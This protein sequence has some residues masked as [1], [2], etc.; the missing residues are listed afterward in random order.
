MVRVP[1]APLVIAGDGPE[2]AELERMARDL[3]LRY[4]SF[5]GLLHGSQLEETIAKCCFSV[6]PSHAYETLGKSILESYAWGRPVV[7][8]DHGSRRELMEHGVT[9][10]LYPVGDREQLA[11]AIELLFG[12]ADLAEKNGSSGAPAAS[13]EARS[14]PVYG[15]D[16]RNVFPTG[17]APEFSF[18]CGPRAF[19]GTHGS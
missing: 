1:H 11:G 15:C 14:R 3:N 4:V 13:A 6:F 17:V 7:A 19:R 18:C 2:R 12:R 16:A 10:L 5:A 8:S 9:G